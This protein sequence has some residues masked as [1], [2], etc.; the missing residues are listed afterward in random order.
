M[1]IGVDESSF[2]KRHEYGTV[3][4]DQESSRV[5]NVVD[6]RTSQNL[7]GFYKTL[8]AQQREGIFSVSMNMW[9]AFIR[10]TVDAVPDAQHKISFHNYHV[11]HVSGGCAG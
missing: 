11:C 3:V 5:L 6:D 8:D 7:N 10:A 1:N 9:P 2:Q 4:T